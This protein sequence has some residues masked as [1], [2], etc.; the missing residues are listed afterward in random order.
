MATPNR[1]FICDDHPIII[2][3]LSVLFEQNSYKLIGHA[4][5]GNELLKALQKVKPDILLLDLHLPD[6]DGLTLIEQIRSVDAYLKIIVLTMYRD[7]FLIKRVEKLGANA[8]LQKNASNSE[9]LQALKSVYETPFH[10]SSTLKAE[11][12][13]LSLVR[14]QFAHKSKLTPRELELIPH[15]AKGKSSSSIAKELRL[16]PLTVDTHRKNIFRKLKINSAIELTNFA[17]ANKLF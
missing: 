13:S 4:T 2:D 12:A 1:I 17:H 16:S 11:T 3:G 8:Y 9:I 5:T 14:D 10:L 15:L 7:D 6:I